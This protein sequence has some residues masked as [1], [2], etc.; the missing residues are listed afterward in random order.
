MDGWG[1]VYVTGHI[2]GGGVN[3]AFSTFKYDVAGNPLW[4]SHYGGSGMSNAIAL[5]VAGNVYVT[6]W[7]QYDRTRRYHHDQIRCERSRTLVSDYLGS[8]SGT[9]TRHLQLPSMPPKCVNWKGKCT[10]AAIP[11]WSPLNPGPPW[12]VD[13]G[14]RATRP[15]DG[16]AQA[17]AIVDRS[18]G[19]VYITGYS[20]GGGARSEY[21]T[22]KYDGAGNQVWAA[23]Y[24]LNRQRGR[25]GLLLV[26]DESGSVFVTGSSLGQGTGSDC[27]TI[28]YLQ[29]GYTDASAR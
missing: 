6:G 10:L 9:L 5:D 15:P 26:V 25:H 28:K 1:N 11:T 16:Y 2:A 23:S 24:T 13:S 21:T 17:S 12:V 7:R 20:D 27:V 4:V 3:A 29:P 8:A 14:W 22:L 18:G 19:D